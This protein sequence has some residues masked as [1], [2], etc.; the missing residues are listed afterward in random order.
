MRCGREKETNRSQATGAVAPSLAL[1]AGFD[2]GDF[3]HCVPAS[4]RIR[5]LVACGA[6]EV[7]GGGAERAGFVAFLFFTVGCL[8]ALE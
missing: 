7:A 5:R 1:V 2:G 8:A 4:E 3:P 6:R